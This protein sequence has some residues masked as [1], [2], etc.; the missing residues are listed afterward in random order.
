MWL[1]Y[2]RARLVGKKTGGYSDPGVIR[3]PSLQWIQCTLAT[4]RKPLWFSKIGPRL[5]KYPPDRPRRVHRRSDSGRQRRGFP[6]Q[7]R[8]SR[9][10]LRRHKCGAPLPSLEALA[11]LVYDGIASGSVLPV[12]QFQ[13]V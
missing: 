1:R 7:R 2:R 5:V 13:L 4:E 9:P 6:G 3:S 12:V 8:H 11:R 10:P